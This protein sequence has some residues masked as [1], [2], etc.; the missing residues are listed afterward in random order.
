MKVNMPMAVT[1]ADT[2]DAV[3]NAWGFNAFGGET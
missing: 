3:G 1:A 2:I